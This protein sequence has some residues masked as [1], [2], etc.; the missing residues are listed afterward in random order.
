LPDGRKNYTKTKPMQ[1]EE[2]TDCIKWFGKKRRE[3]NDFAWMVAIDEVLRY[4]KDGGLLSANLD[5]KNPNSQ[6]ALEHLPPEQLAA[7]ILDKEQKIID[8]I[9]DVQAELEGVKA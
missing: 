4:D 9:E 6:E 5:V 1:F 7:D 3:D 8:I 2:L